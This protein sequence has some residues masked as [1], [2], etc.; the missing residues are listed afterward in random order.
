MLDRPTVTRGDETALSILT[1]AFVGIDRVSQVSYPVDKTDRTVLLDTQGNEIARSHD[2][3]IIVRRCRPVPRSGLGLIRPANGNH[4][5]AHDDEATV[6]IPIT[7]VVGY[8]QNP[9]I[10]GD[11]F[12]LEIDCNDWGI[13]S[14]LIGWIAD[15]PDS[16][17]GNPV[18]TPAT[19]NGATARPTAR[20]R[21]VPS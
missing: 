7:P 3:F 9:L 12:V 18:S 20:G 21:P 14:Q 5:I 13:A 16:N 6:G 15:N 10:R 19:T 17:R 11:R 2:G 8:R 4:P 1:G